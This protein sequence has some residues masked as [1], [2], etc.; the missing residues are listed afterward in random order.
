[1][2]FELISSVLSAGTV[3]LCMSSV[4]AQHGGTL[5]PI[6]GRWGSIRAGKPTITGQGRYLDDV[7][8]LLIVTM[9]MT[10]A[11]T[12]TITMT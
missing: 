5:P 3:T 9:T 11:I 8:I 1:M 2:V 12:I 10:I 6:L 7:K 4:A